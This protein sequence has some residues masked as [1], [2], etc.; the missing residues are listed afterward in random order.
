MGGQKGEERSNHIVLR[1]AVGRRMKTATSR[2][3]FSRNVLSNITHRIEEE[4]EEEEGSLGIAYRRS[5]VPSV[6]L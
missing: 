5:Y 6:Y 1:L 2:F 4:E 3:V